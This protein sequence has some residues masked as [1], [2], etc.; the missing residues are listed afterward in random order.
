[1]SLLV[2]DWT[3]NQ[4]LDLLWFFPG[5]QPVCLG[6]RRGDREH[7]ADR[8]DPVVCQNSALLK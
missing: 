2:S 3:F 7:P 4:D 8:L 6:G 1:M 5:A